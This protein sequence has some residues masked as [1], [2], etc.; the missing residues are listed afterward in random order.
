MAIKVIDRFPGANAR[1]LAVRDDAKAPEIVFTPDPR[2]GT[3]ALWFD[4]RVHDPSPPA[5]GA[6]E[7]LKLSLAFFET[8]LGGSNPAAIRPVLRER[9]K[10]WSRLKP[11]EVK[12]EPDGLQT[13]SWSV[14]YPVEPHEFAL[15]M[16]YTY[17]ELATALEHCKGYWTSSDIGLTQGGKVLQRLS[18]DILKGCKACPNPHGL[19]ILARQHA[20]ETPG[21]WVLDGMLEAFSRAKP[22]NWC[23]WIVPFANL[24]D[25]LSGSYGKD[26]FP[27]D[28]N[29]AWGDPPMRHETLVMRHDIRR[30]AQRCKPELVLDLHAP[31]AS[32]NDGVYAYSQKN[33]TPESEKANQAWLN[34][35]AQALAPDYAAETFARV[36]DYPSR[37]PQPWLGDFV[38]DAIGTAAVSL[39]TPYCAI[40]DTV[41]LQKHYREIGQRLARAI[42]TRWGR[43]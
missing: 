42:L 13:L 43:G 36:A 18:N 26:P 24:D 27:H 39:E 40:R 10:A 33:G 15:C 19:Y 5:A 28:L 12:T 35:F 9:G 30:W 7:S 29:R 17:D 22:V 3:E 4:F 38:R 8:L 11:P 25:V 2:G 21:S 31:G 41:L 16:P 32:E 6:P 14:P 23:V 37:W 34:L 1:I 20:G